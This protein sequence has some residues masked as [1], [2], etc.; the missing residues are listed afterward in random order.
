[1]TRSPVIDI[2]LQID[3]DT[4]IHY[5]D[6][7]EDFKVGLL[8]CSYAT[9]SVEEL[10]EIYFN[11]DICMREFASIHNICNQKNVEKMHIFRLAIEIY[12]FLSQE[13][14]DAFFVQEKTKDKE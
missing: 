7:K 1:M 6:A 3:G 10:V 13:E 2:L 9:C 11:Q 4:I 12:K 5:R 14:D 8:I